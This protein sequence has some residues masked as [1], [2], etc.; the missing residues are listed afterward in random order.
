MTKLLVFRLIKATF[1]QEK[2]FATGYR[3][4]KK[5]EKKVPAGPIN[6]LTLTTKAFYPAPTGII[7]KD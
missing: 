3:F 4:V 1:A 5:I 2:S 7:L 6:I